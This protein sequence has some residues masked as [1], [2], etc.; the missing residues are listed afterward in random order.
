MRP[1]RPP[2]VAD[3]IASDPPGS[4]VLRQLACGS[5]N[6]GQ[7]AVY[8]VGGAAALQKACDAHPDSA[9]IKENVAAVGEALAKVKPL[10]L[11][12]AANDDEMDEPSSAA[13]SQ[14]TSKAKGAGGDVS[15]RADSKMV[16]GD[17]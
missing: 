8:N 10:A 5:T 15:I 13:S 6:A 1:R 12:P 2:R 7:M 9:T 11:A 16:S 17:I 14:R 3:V 4:T